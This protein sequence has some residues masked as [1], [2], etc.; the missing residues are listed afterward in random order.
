MGWTV[1]TNSRGPI[2]DADN[3]EALSYVNESPERWNYGGNYYTDAAKTIR[4][5]TASNRLPG[6]RDGEKQYAISAYQ[7][8]EDHPGD[9]WVTKGNLQGR[10]PGVGMDLKIYLN[11]TLK[12]DEVA[13]L[14]S[15][16][17][18]FQC[19]LGPVKKGD[20]AYVAVASED[21]NTLIVRLLYTI[22]SFAKGT[23]PPPPAQM[24]HPAPDTAT[25]VMSLRTVSPDEGYLQKHKS[26]CD[27]LIEKKPELVFIGDSITSRLGTPEMLNSR[28]GEKYK[29]GMFAIGGDWMQNVL[30]RIENGPLEQIKPKAIVLLIGTN[31]VK[32]Y[33]PDEIAL[34]IGKIV[35]TLHRQTPATEIVLMGIFP[36]GESIH[37]NPRYEKIKQ[38]NKSLEQLAENSD[39]VTFLDI[40][41]RLVEEDGTIS[42]EIMPDL[43]HVAPKGLDIWAEGLSPILTRIFHTQS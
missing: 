12:F 23:L 20:V 31:N 2:G 36:R 38:I 1:L 30:W 29:P 32:N 34:G 3:Y 39:R 16:P 10:E 7:F 41:D 33:T 15:K 26:L 8:S 21:T 17:H 43:L 37:N 35:Q 13:P 42:K 22:E 28:F 25:P 6:I 5:G 4:A 9:V 14:A 27:A 18:L 24:I 40:G 11:D 19:N